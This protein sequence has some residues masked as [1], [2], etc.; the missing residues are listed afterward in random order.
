MALRGVIGER[1]IGVTSG[2]GGRT[3]WPNDDFDVEDIADAKG[4][5]ATKAQKAILRDQHETRHAATKN[6]RQEMPESFLAVVQLTAQISD[7]LNVSESCLGAVPFEPR[8]VSLHL[9]GLVVRRDTGIADGL[10]CGSGL[11]A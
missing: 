8:G 3:A 4:Q 9:F 6:V 7:D 5:F 11:N 2:L 1:G 10:A